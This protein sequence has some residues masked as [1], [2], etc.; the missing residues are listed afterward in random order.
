MEAQ[1][2]KRDVAIEGLKKQLEEVIET[3]KELK[4]EIK[5]RFNIM[6]LK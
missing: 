1:G 5:V 3:N 2:N 6:K 4:E